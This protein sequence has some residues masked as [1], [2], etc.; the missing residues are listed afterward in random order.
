MQSYFTGENCVEIVM[1]SWRMFITADADV[2]EQEPKRY[3][4]Q[5]TLLGW[6]HMQMRGLQ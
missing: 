3:E 5:I 6:E 2:G 1:R 4:R